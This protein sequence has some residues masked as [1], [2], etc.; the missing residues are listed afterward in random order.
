LAALLEHLHRRLRIKLT[1]MLLGGFVTTAAAAHHQGTVGVVR[2][3]E[4]AHG[5]TSQKQDVKP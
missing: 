4:L 3:E 1:L 2:I 5:S